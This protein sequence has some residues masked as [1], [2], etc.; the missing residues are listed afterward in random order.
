[1]VARKRIA[2]IALLLVIMVGIA[3]AA[4]LKAVSGYGDA[5]IYNDSFKA[6]RNPSQISD[7]YVIRTA[8]DGLV[9]SGDDIRI[10]I[11]PGSLVRIISLGDNPEIYVLDGKA[12]VFSHKTFTA[13]TTVVSYHA[14]GGTTIYVVTE[15]RLETAYVK[16]NAVIATNLITGKK[17]IVNPGKYPE[18]PEKAA[19][20]EETT[21]AETTPEPIVE[22]ERVLMSR[23]IGYQGFSATVTACDGEAVIEYPA[24]VTGEELIDALQAVFAG[25]PEFADAIMVSLG[26][27]G[28]AYAYYPAEYGEEGF[29][30][31]IDI[32]EKELPPYLDNLFAMYAAQAAAEAEAK[33]A[34]EKAA[35]QTEVLVPYEIVGDPVAPETTAPETEPSPLVWTFD[36]RGIEAEV[37]A[38]VG[39]ADVIYPAAVTNEE[40]DTAAAALVATY[41][42][43]TQ[44]ITYEILRPGLAKLSYPESYGPAEFEFAT[45]IIDTELRA[46]IDWIIASMQTQPEEGTIEVPEE[47]ASQA[48]STKTPIEVSPRPTEQEQP[49]EQPAEKEKSLFNF[50]LSIGFVAGGNGTEGDYYYA[51]SFINRRI[52]MFA[53]NFTITIDP[54]FE[55]GNF[56]L[57]LRLKVE[58]KDGKF[59]NPF[60]FN[61][62]GRTNLAYSIMQY[63]S[64]FGF[65][66]DNGVFSI[67]AERNVGIGFTSAIHDPFKVDFENEDRLTLN[68]A[69]KVGGFTFS[70]F[71]E[72]LQFKNKL[73][74]RSDYSGVR[75]SYEFNGFEIGV[76]AIVDVKRGL[77]HMIFYPGADFRMNFTLGTQEFDFSVQAAAQIENG[78]LNAILGK[79]SFDTIL[80]N[81]LVF[82]LGAAYNHGSHINDLMNNGPVEVMRQYSGNSIDASLKAGLVFGPF[83]I[84]GNFTIPFKLKIDGGMLVYNVV[85]TRNDKYM[86][87]TADT[88]DARAELV[89]GD[90]KFSTGVVFNGFS[91]RLSN[92]VKSLVSK[93]EMVKNLKAMLDPE[94]ATYF[95]LATYSTEIGNVKLSTFSRI[96]LARVD[97]YLTIPFSTGLVVSF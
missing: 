1:M 14:E 34:A 15:D 13:R 53:K 30:R 83:S 54:R 77:A 16:T 78:K 60:S 50:G 31:A 90:F 88:F 79:V 37:I 18:E 8:E 61:P 48:E 55:I 25:Y 12:E 56:N 94:I 9:L 66:T 67:H 28:T 68:G 29:N 43:Y 58:V 42:E 49:E 32:I 95:A 10:R 33:A 45:G 52:G 36:Y 38:Y 65:A 80:D 3:F 89:L 4:P 62:N 71:V 63:V 39:T 20:P 23:T 59:I 96:D 47:E 97:G 2:A 87:I 11:L 93:S 26:E 17:A 64:G 7:G 74:G 81:W 46:Y 92:L 86:S 75:A 84:I 91:G 27:P 44:G 6:V 5:R 35:E 57:G 72:D 76:S 19:A 82:G 85:R 73:N 51:P 70:V 22:T 69:V 24:F 41:P 21:P 40:I